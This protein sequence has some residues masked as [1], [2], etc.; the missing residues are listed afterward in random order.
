MLD[1]AAEVGVSVEEGVGDAGFTLDG[2]KGDRHT[3][4]DQGADGLFGGSGLRLGFGLR[5]GGQHGDAV[6]PGRRSRLVPSLGREVQGQR[7]GPAWGCAA[8]A[9]LHRPARVVGHGGQ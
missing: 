7:D 3:A 8:A 4:L 9:A 1:P 2:L 5:S 6:G